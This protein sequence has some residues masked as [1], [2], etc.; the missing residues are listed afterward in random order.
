MAEPIELVSGTEGKAL[1][2][3]AAVPSFERFF[4]TTYPRLFGALCLIT[5]NRHESEEIAQDAYL[6]LWERWNRVGGI[7]D[8]EAY[9]FRVAMNAF[10]MRLRRALLAAR[11]SAGMIPA[12]DGIAEIEARDVAV[13]ALAELS[14]Q[15]RAAV[16]LTDL[17][18]YPS[19]EVGRLLGI[20]AST[21]RMHVSRGR[22]ALKKTMGDANE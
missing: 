17:L 7:S 12:D 19:E 15:Q 13:R 9:L 16:V 18:G 21:V 4:E 14:P 20:R 10:R 6:K 8:P 5:R 2:D 1:G 3:E 22:A 11:R